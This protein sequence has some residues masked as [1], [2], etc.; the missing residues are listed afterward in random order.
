MLK[1]TGLIEGHYECRSLDET[2]PVFTDL[3]AMEIV[4]RKA[5]QA[6]IKHPNT[7]W[8]LIVHEGGPGAPEKTFDNHYGFRVATHTEV[9]AAWEYVE[10]HKDKYRIS[11][12]TKPQ[13]AHFAYSI[14]FREPGGNHL[15][16]EYYNPGGAL[17]GR[18]HTAGHWGNTLNS[19]RFPGRGYVPQAFTHG[20]LQCDD[21]ERSRRFYV[22]VLG[23]E[24]AAGFNTAQYIKHPAAPWY[25]VVLQ[26]SPRQYLAPVNRFTLQ[27]ASAAEV[28]QAHR[29]FVSNNKSL[30]LNEIAEIDRTDGTVN[31]IFSDLDKN[32]WELTANG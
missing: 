20:T 11:K 25:L 3:L 8:R 18:S 32:W 22:E 24:I 1:T 17:H 7:D 26:R 10:A 12:I 9:E 27:L 29:E 4:E 13:S 16:I 21:I 23:L 30:G 28:E 19:E 31:F 5:G 2:L 14:Y 6:T 15:E